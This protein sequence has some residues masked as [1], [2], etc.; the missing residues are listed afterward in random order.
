MEETEKH[1]LQIILPAIVV[2]VMVAIVVGS[3]LFPPGRLSGENTATKASSATN[4]VQPP[5]DGQ[6]ENG[7][8]VATGFIAEGDY[9]IV[10]ATCT[11]CHSSSLV[12]QNRAT[13]EGWESMIRWMQANQKLWDL[14]VNEPKILDYLAK[15][16]GPPENAGRRQNLVVEEWYPI[17]NDN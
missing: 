6:V 12:L 1:K 8:D 14:G 2:A 10:K 15:H 13:R 17:G 5:D 11:A 7:K 4:Y 16:Y 3:T 9:Q